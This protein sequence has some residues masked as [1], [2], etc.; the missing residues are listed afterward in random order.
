M[1]LWDIII[2]H[3]TEIQDLL[4]FRRL[5][6]STKNMVDALI[7]N[8]DISETFPYR[9]FIRQNTCMTCDAI[10]NNI[11][12]FQ[13]THEP[14]PRRQLHTCSNKDCF[15]KS[16]RRF[17]EDANKDHVYPFVHF[18]HALQ[19]IPRTDNT[20]SVGKIVHNSPLFEDKRT[21]QI[22]ALTCFE[23]NKHVVKTDE[24]LFENEKFFNFVKYVP[25]QQLQSNH[26]IEYIFSSMFNVFQ[27]YKKI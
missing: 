13:Y 24:K 25:I 9:T 23:E 14:L 17:I 19:W 15:T 26:R 22:C 12:S 27:K 20:F 5:E 11:F 7:I 8:A 2:A 21:N 16:L 6:K 10:T 1:E 18:N 3:I 4:T